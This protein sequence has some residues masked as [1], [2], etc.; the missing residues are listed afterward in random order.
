M[1][2][3]LL[4]F[5]SILFILFT[6]AATAQTTYTWNGGSGDWN[7]A[8][9][10]TPVGVPGAGDNAVI[11]SGTVTL[12]T[13]VTVAGLELSSELTGDFN[14]TV[15]NLMIWNWGTMAGNGV[16]TIAVGATLRLI[17]TNQQTLYRQIDNNGTTIWEAGQFYLGN[18]IAFNNNGTFLDQHSISQTLSGGINGCI[19]NNNG[20]YTKNSS[21]DSRLDLPFYNNGTLDLQVGSMQLNYEGTSD[22][23][24][25][26][27]DGF[28]LKIQGLPQWDINGPIDGAGIVEFWTKTII[29]GNYNITGNTVFASNIITFD[30]SAT[31][32][33]LNGGQEL[34]ISGTAEFNTGDEIVIDSLYLS[35]HLQG[36]DMVTIAKSMIWNSGI[37]Q[38]VGVTTIDAG[39]TLRLSGTNQQSLFR[40]IDNNGTTIWE[41][42]Q[43]YLGNNIAFNNNGTFLDQHPIGQVLTGGINGCVFNNNGI[44]TKSS[45]GASSINLPFYNI[46]GS[47]IRGTGTMQITDVFTNEGTVGPGDSLGTL[48]LDTDYPTTPTSSLNI[49]IGGSPTSGLYDR[50]E[51]TGAATLDGTLNISLVNNFVPALGDTFEVLTYSSYN[52]NFST[53][54]GLNTGTGI[55]FDT[56][57]T[58]TALLIITVA[59]SDIEE[60]FNSI[61]KEYA[62]AQNYPNPFNPSTN[63]KYSIPEASFVQLKVYDILGNEVATLVNEEQNI[64]NYNI[65]FNASAL[66]S[67]VYFYRIQAGSFVDTKKMLLLK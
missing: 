64:G 9:N 22:G 60:N 24:I 67:G 54:N 17:G 30:T 31:I 45:T 44:Y 56:V 19:F 59:T 27:D 39:A 46:P 1:K 37:M 5:I 32:V 29:R 52:G 55:A 23:S 38:G 33:S 3:L 2:N 42:G 8:S 40:Q 36:S 18:N 28:L 49:E 65:E 48:T 61:P 12:T 34:V 66:P 57:F 41:A 21:G 16:T 51:T 58:S 15:T 14:F 50:L 35:G 53:I 7:V 11:N 63:I 13:D 26:I 10:W 47:D 62:L 43:F 6:Y 4:L 20:T 25:N